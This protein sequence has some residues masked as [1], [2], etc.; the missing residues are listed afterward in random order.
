MYKTSITVDTDSTF[1]AN[2]D[3][4]V[5]SQ[6]S[7]KTYVDAIGTPLQLFTTV[8]DGTATASVELVPAV[9]GK[10]FFVTHVCYMTTASADLGGDFELN[11]D[12]NGGA[13]IIGGLTTTTV[14]SY[15]IKLV[16]PA[17][18]SVAT[19]AEAA[20]VADVTGDT[21]EGASLTFQITVI[22]FYV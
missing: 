7:V 12:Y 6:K 2:S 9:T 14:G 13:T 18:S 5:P 22:G 10:T 21:G 16:D 3:N 8:I 1:A 11:V 20:V 19:T 15:L 4:R 17:E